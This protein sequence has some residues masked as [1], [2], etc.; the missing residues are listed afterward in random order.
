MLKKAIVAALAMSC[1]LGPG[2]FGAEPAATTFLNGDWEGTITEVPPQAER[3]GDFKIRLRIEGERAQVWLLGES[4]QWEDIKP[5][6]FKAFQHNFNAVVFANDSWRG[7]C[8]DE[9]WTYALA[10]DGANQLL[11]KYSRVVSNVRCMKATAETFGRQASGM[12][13][14]QTTAPAAAH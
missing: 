1:L 13:I 8:W 2:A 5:G 14:P 10:L 7:D 11:A 12:L 9:T 6:K 3:K 4:G